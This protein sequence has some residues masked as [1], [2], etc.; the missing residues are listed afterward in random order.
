M[1]DPPLQDDGP[2]SDGS[3]QTDLLEDKSIEELRREHDQ[4]VCE[5]YFELADDLNRRIKALTE[6]S[7]NQAVDSFMKEFEQQCQRHQ[8]THR[9]DRQEIDAKR[10]LREIEIR[11]RYSEAFALKQQEQQRQLRDFE[12]RQLLAYKM[13]TN[14][15][16][17]KVENLAARA[18]QAGKD[19]NY[20][21]A[22]QLRDDARDLQT[23]KLEKRTQK[24]E[25]GNKVLANKMLDEQ[26]QALQ[27]LSEALSRDLA[28]FEGS[29]EKEYEAELR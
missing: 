12:N 25:E 15:P 5:M 26:R 2:L 13:L 7:L 21:E 28:T 19:G 8:I 23:K 16:I 10:H 22:K 17:E 29:R 4:A 24:F 14:K 20:E 6:R 9:N 27:S 3:S 18:R 1:S 11:E